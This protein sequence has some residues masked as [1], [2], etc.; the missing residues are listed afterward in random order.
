M[1]NKH[2]A[3]VQAIR[4]ISGGTAIG[5]AMDR[6]ITEFT[7]NGRSD[8][9]KL[10]VVITDGQSQ[11]SVTSAATRARYSCQLIVYTLQWA[12]FY[13]WVLSSI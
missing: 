6:A 5:S 8:A 10:M 7:S 11:D 12:S 3:D 9:T 4:Q 13:F 1:K 2:S